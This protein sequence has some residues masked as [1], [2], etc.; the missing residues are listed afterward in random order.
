MLCVFAIPITA[1]TVLSDFGYGTDKGFWYD[2]E[3]FTAQFA[4]YGSIIL[5]GYYGFKRLIKKKETQKQLT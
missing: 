4:L 2:V 3:S 5:G 1:V